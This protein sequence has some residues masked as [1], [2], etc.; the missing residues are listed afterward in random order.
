MTFSFLGNS[1][2]YFIR[3]SPLTLG[4]GNFLAQ[5]IAKHLSR[6]MRKKLMIGNLI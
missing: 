6:I 3:N 1:I 2:N 5:K 4:R